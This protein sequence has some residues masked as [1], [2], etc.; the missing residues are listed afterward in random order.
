VTSYPH[1]GPVAEAADAQFAV[2]AQ[3]CL[4]DL[5]Q[6]SP[7]RA[8]A[9]GD[10]RFDDQ[11]PD[12]SAAGRGDLADAMTRRL[13][14]LDAVDDTVLGTA[15]LLDFETL[16]AALAAAEFE[17]TEMRRFEWDPRVW[18]PGDAVW[19]LLSRP[20]LEPDELARALTGRLRSVPEFL[21]VGRHTLGNMPR[22]NC[23]TAVSQLVG[24]ESLLG[25]TIDDVAASDP[26]LARGLLSA[27]DAAVK[28]LQEHRGWLSDRL[29]SE[30][31]VSRDSRLG[32]PKFAAALWHA[33]D[34]GPDVASLY[35]TASRALEDT[36]AALTEISAMLLNEREDA[37]DLVDRALAAVAASGV[38]DESTILP[39]ARTALAAV[40]EFTRQHDFVTL[41]D[42]DIDVVVMP[43]IHRGVAVAYCDSPGPLET[44]RLPTM[45][46]VAPPPATW[47]LDQQ[48]SFYREYNAHMLHSLSIHEGVPGHA[49]QLAHSRQLCAPTPMRQVFRNGAFVEGWAVYTEYVFAENEYPGMDVA[50][51]DLAWQLTYLK[52]RLRGIVNLLLDIG[53]HCN[54]LTESEAMHMMLHRAHQEPGEASGK[55]RR[56]MQTAGQLST[57][58]AGFLEVSAIASDL[59]TMHPEFGYREVHDT[60]LSFGSPSTRVLRQALGLPE[61]L[62]V[63]F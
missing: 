47:S 2:L 43:E 42:A 28:A 41:I 1:A 20:V 55:W 14:Q 57:Y 10:H 58:F 26:A 24:T 8:T 53:V 52:T 30:V 61:L 5:L 9:L 33:L 4:D 12:L 60:M 59:R 56:A 19:Q 45:Y 16:R 40:T 23:E 46:A 48:Q 44:K 34:G 17:A 13:E 22:I 3:E 31:G 18:N 15:A 62:S 49:L 27:R 50:N 32:E 21:A 36:H 29:A 63:P 54:D 51:G 7:D 11:L 25:T 6:R 39:T 37:P 35:N 38:I